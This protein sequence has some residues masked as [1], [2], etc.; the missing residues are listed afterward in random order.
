MKPIALMVFLLLQLLPAVP[1][2]GQALFLPPELSWWILEVQKANPTVSTTRFTFEGTMTGNMEAG[3]TNTNLIYPVF[4]IWN[5]SADLYAYLFFGTGIVKQSDGRY[6]PLFDIDSG[7]LVVNR[8][9]V[10]IYQEPNGTQS[11]PCAAAWLRDRVLVVVGIDIVDRTNDKTVVDLWAR[12]FKFGTQ[13]V[14]I[15]LYSFRDAFNNDL[16]SI[17]HLDWWQQRPDYFVV[18]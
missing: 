17:L 11:G 12:I 8:S 15:E 9:G 1:I 3:R 10:T 14:Q 7:L 4:K 13:K 6:A 5:Y 18:D 2:Q 16:R